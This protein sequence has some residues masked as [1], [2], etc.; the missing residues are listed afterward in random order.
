M[1]DKIFVDTNVLIYLISNETDKRNKCR[2]LFG[3]L[4]TEAKLVWSTQVVQEFVNVCRMKFAHDPSLIKEFLNEFEHL[5]LVQ[6]SYD[7][8]MT[9]LEIQKDHKISFWDSLIVAAAKQGKC[10]MVLSEDLNPSQL[11]SGIKV[12]SP[13]DFNL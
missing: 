2:S 3:R 12:V 8:I 9:A 11:I 10:S 5:K 4:E 13:F 1:K 7:T 6:N